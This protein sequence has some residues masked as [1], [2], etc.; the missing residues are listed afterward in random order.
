MTTVALTHNYRNR[1]ANVHP[2]SECTRIST[3][4]SRSSLSFNQYSSLKSQHLWC[5][6]NVDVAFTGHKF[7]TWGKISFFLVRKETNP[8][9]YVWR[10]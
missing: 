10:N 4:V 7:I 8:F 2:A 6:S 9:F 1:L 3:E 5:L